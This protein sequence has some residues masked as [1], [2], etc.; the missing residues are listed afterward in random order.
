MIAKEQAAEILRALSALPAD[1]IAEVHDYVFFLKE[2]Y[3]VQSQDNWTDEDVHD[4]TV[5]TLAYADETH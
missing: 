3:G 4:F 1:K 5:A 2:C